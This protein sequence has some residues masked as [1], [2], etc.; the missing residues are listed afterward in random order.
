[1]VWLL[2]ENGLPVELT[3]STRPGYRV[4]EDDNQVVCEPFSDR[5]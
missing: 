5:R 1:M 2:G 4:Y 3:T